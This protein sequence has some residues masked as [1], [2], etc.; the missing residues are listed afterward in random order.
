M[1]RRIAAALGAGTLLVAGAAPAGAAVVPLVD[2]AAPT[3][4]GVHVVYFGYRNAGGRTTIPIGDSNQVYPGVQNQGQPTVFNTGTYPRVFRADLITFAFTGIVWSLD[5]TDAVMQTADVN[6][7]GACGGPLLAP[8]VGGAPHVGEPVLASLGTWVAVLRGNLQA[9]WQRSSDGTAWEDI[10]VPVTAAL[11]TASYTPEAQDLGYLLRVHVT[12]TGLLAPPDDPSVSDSPASEA[13]KG[14]RGSLAVHD[15]AQVLGAPAIPGRKLYGERASFNGAPAATEYTTVW[16]SRPDAGSPWSE[17]AT[18]LTFVVPNVLVGQQ[19]RFA[20]LA[21]DGEGGVVTAGS[22]P[23]PVYVPPRRVSAPHITGSAVVNGDMT[24]DPGTWSGDP[25]PVVT[26]TWQRCD[27][28]VCHNIAGA[29]GTTYSPKAADVGRTLRVK[30]VA[31]NAYAA[32]SA[33]T[34]ETAPVSP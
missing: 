18:G 1:L 27:A 15:P 22:P 32:A 19:L 30:V 24:L 4:S 10:G 7:S 33:F 3:P 34:T 12:A 23:L 17:V 20:N 29:V 26:Q 2:C 14:A 28:G 13:V 8:A 11:M 21:D 31:R 9:V 25:T 16:Q 5:G 6:S